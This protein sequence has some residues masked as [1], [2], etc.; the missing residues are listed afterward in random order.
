MAFLE[1][2]NVR[3]AGIASGVPETIVSNY[4]LQPGIDII[5]LFLVKHH[6]QLVWRSV[7][8]QTPCALPIY[9]LQQL[10]N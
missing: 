7:G 6:V 9:A 10:K 3:I 2:K 8:A 5:L 1:Y 4:T